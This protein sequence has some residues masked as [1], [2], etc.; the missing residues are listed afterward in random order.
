MIKVVVIAMVPIHLCM[1]VRVVFTFLR[2][3]MAVR[4]FTM[5]QVMHQI[6][7]QH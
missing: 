4:K 3:E 7:A 5:K 1:G 2:V 6:K